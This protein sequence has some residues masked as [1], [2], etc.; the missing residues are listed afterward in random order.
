MYSKIEFLSSKIKGN[1]DPLNQLIEVFFHPGLITE[2]H[3]EIQWHP[4]EEEQE[5]ASVCVGFSQYPVEASLINE[6]ANHKRYKTCENPKE[7]GRNHP[8][9][10]HYVGSQDKEYKNPVD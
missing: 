5:G 3:K 10:L 6:G 7:Q 2:V 8:I 9:G 1:W 4:K